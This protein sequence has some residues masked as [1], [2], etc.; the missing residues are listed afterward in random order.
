MYKRQPRKPIQYWGTL[1]LKD[2]AKHL[3]SKIRG[4]GLVVN[5]SKPAP[6]TTPHSNMS[7]IENI[8]SEMTEDNPTPLAV[9]SG[10]MKKKSKGYGHT[11][12]IPEPSSKFIVPPILD[13]P[14]LKM[15]TLDDFEMPPKK[16]VYKK[17]T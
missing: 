7:K 5:Q 4:D 15:A 14:P 11:D 17:R 13:Q 10:K 1:L 2:E 3:K 9:G 16:R 12:P 6:E 8:L